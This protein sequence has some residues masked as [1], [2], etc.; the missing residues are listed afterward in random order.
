V[1]PKKKVFKRE[2]KM[3]TYSKEKVVR[4]GKLNCPPP[5]HAWR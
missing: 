4:R 1:I 2:K 5:S 3:F